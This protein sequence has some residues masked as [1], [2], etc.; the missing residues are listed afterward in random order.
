M[1]AGFENDPGCYDS[2]RM[3]YAGGAQRIVWTRHAETLYDRPLRMR[4]TGL[5]DVARYRV[6]VVYG[7]D[8]PARKLRLVTGTGVVV[9]DW[10]AKPVPQRPLS[11][12]I[13][14]GAVANGELVLE[15]SGEPGAGSN[16]RGCQLSEVW[17]TRARP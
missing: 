14:A 9:H 17:L 15:W 4:Y 10:L 12:D 3:G 16:G 2:V 1:G 11:F 8:N 13:P 6:R 5:D 7:P